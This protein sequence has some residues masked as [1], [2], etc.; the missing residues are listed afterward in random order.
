MSNDTTAPGQTPGQTSEKSAR[1]LS[2]P[3]GASIA[4]HALEATKSKSS[5]ENLPGIV[6]MPGF[7]SDMSGDKALTLEKYSQ[8]N[9]NAFVRFDYQGH[10]QSS[11]EFSEGH[12]GIWSDDALA[13][14]DELTEGPQILV[15]SSMG[16]WVMLLTALAR[17]D[18]IAGLVGIA[19]APDFTE[20]LL[21][22]ELTA[23]Q[24]TEV[25]E[26]G[27]VIV[28]SD[29]EDDYVFT[30]KLF[31]Q[32][33]KHLVLRDEISLDCP[34]RLLHGLEDPTVPWQTALKIQ[35]KLR[36]T[37][38]EVTLIKNGDHRLSEAQ[39][40]ERLTRTIAAL[41]DGL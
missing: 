5:G 27:F 23:E 17:P 6:F 38:V 35:E 32:G 19:A 1:S 2:R 41:M 28:P 39:D 37:D 24:M 4:Y 16:G 30:K 7:M 33:R 3:A 10:G 18:R 14:L 12:I 31:E 15:G 11:G 34:V 8:S 22:N 20:D 26:N 36:G 9:G 13:V 25:E 29:Y 21:P 40:L